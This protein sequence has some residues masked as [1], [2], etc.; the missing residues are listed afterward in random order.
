[1][2]VHNSTITIEWEKLMVIKIS[3]WFGIQ[4]GLLP[5]LLLQP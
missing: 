4:N 3:E 2:L 1:M 5:L